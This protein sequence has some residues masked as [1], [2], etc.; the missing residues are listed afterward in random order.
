MTESDDAGVG[1]QFVQ[2]V[3][4][5]DLLSSIAAEDQQ[6]DV[7]ECRTTWRSS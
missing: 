4:A 6:L 1:E 2:R 7:G 3:A 5:L